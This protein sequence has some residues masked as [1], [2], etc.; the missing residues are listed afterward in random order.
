MEALLTG[1]AHVRNLNQSHPVLI[2]NAFQG[3]R[4]QTNHNAVTRLYLA[5]L[6]LENRTRWS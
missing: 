1:L 5:H 3:N 6:T 4:T 2:G